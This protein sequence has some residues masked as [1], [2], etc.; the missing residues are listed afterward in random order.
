[1]LG[2]RCEVARRRFARLQGRGGWPQQDSTAGGASG[3]APGTA[4]LRAGDAAVARFAHA[5]AVDARAA[6]RADHAPRRRR[7]RRRRAPHR[8]RAACNRRA[9][10]LF[11]RAL[12]LRA[13]SRRP[14][15]LLRLVQLLL[16][17][18]VVAVLL[19][20]GRRGQPVFGG[21]GAGAR[22]DLANLA[23]RALAAYAD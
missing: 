1:M 6:P 12:A 2:S 19:R 4:A 7:A 17:G 11:V 9:L 13:S 23:R 22:A 14:L 16:L 3:R 15:L 21:G 20:R 8:R 18:V 5:R 10:A